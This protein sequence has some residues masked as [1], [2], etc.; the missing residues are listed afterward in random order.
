ML[1]QTISQL[2]M[3]SQRLTPTT[4]SKPW[5]Q[6][7]KLNV[8][9]PKLKQSKKLLKKPEIISFNHNQLM[10]SLIKSSNL[11][12]NLKT[13]SKKTINMKMKTH[14]KKKRMMVLMKKILLSLKKKTRMNN[15]SNSTLVKL[16][17]F[18]SKLT[19]TTLPTLFKS[20]GLKLSQKLN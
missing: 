14:K 17:V 8:L 1:I 3:K 4:S 18:F 12:N 7:L 16:L 20:F 11:L 13:E 6:K 15:N 19:K 5:N 10:N 2:S 9:S